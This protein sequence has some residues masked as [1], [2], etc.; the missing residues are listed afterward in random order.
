MEGQSV[1]PPLPWLIYLISDEVGG[2]W[3]DGGCAAPM[4]DL[5]GLGK[6]DWGVSEE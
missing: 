2:G 4:P 1:H 6:R 5:F 3:K